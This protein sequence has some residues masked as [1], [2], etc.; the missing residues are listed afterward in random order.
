MGWGTV[1]ESSPICSVVDSAA[2]MRGLVTEKSADCVTLFNIA[3]RPQDRPNS[4]R[5][6]VSP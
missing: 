6:D 3:L 1:L 2:E 5:C 4:G